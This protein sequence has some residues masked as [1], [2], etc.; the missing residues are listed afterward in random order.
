[1]ISLFQSIGHG[2]DMVLLPQGNLADYD[3][4]ES[5]KGG[6]EQESILSSTTPDPGYNMGK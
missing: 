3:F 6:K 5:K 2:I 4:H 1:M